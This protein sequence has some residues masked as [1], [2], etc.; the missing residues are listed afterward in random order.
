MPPD[1][2]VITKRDCIAQHW[3]S[4]MKIWHHPIIYNLL[5]QSHKW[6]H[7]TIITTSTKQLKLHSVKDITLPERNKEKARWYNQFVMEIMVRCYHNYQRPGIHWGEIISKA[8]QSR[9]T[10][11]IKLHNLFL[12]NVGP[13]IIA[14][15]A[16][17]LT[18]C[19]PHG[20]P[21]F[22]YVPVLFTIY[23]YTATAAPVIVRRDLAINWTIAVTLVFGVF[24]YK[25]WLGQSDMQ[26]REKKEWQSIRTVW[27]I[28]SWYD[29]ARTAAYRLRRA[30]DR[31]K[32]NYNIRNQIFTEKQSLSSTSS[33][34]A[35]LIL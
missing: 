14:A 19:R 23:V 28:D 18:G 1:D 30:T 9:G 20:N 33:I 4:T 6:L 22:R 31:F 13:V 3:E 12:I 27:C 11:L 16:Y 8:A 7:V 2:S 15:V 10:S 25:K 29:R 5:I 24:G 35:L 32:K 26:T 34:C 21:M 17:R